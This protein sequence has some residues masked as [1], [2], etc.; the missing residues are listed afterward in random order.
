LAIYLR[1]YELLPSER[2]AEIF[3][4]I[5][6]VPLSEGTLY[7]TTE[8]CADEL[9]GFHDWIIKKLIRSEIVNFDE[10]GL[11]IGGSLHWLHSASTENLTYYYPHEKRGTEAFDEIGILP[12]FKGYAVHDHWKSYFNYDCLHI[13]CNGHHL[14][15]LTYVYEVEEQRWADKMIKL[16]CE[17][18]EESEKSAKK[19]MVLKES[20]QK[21]YE[22]KYSYILSEG[23]LANPPPEEPIVKKRGRKKKGKVLNLLERMKNYRNEIL[24][25]MYD[26]NIPFDNNLAERDIRMI[27]VQQKISGLFRTKAGAEQFCVIRSFIST[28]RK[29]GLNVIDAIHD[30]LNGKQIYLNFSC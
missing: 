26:T 17:I 3:E 7:N 30:V 6:S 8:R 28:A 20:W 27:K 12:N 19:G 29:Q 21:M 18:K 22:R 13:L 10:S 23:F 2:T 1:D 5:F 25:F 9:N 14:R 15:E 24:A 16:L 4:D 11:N